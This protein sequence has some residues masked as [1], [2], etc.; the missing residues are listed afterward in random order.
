M[1]HQNELTDEELA[2]ASGGANAL[3]DAFVQGFNNGRARKQRLHP[4]LPELDRGVLLG[5]WR[6][7]RFNAC[8]S[9]RAPIATV[10]SIDLRQGSFVRLDRFSR[11]GPRIE[12][13]LDAD[14]GIRL[15]DHGWANAGDA[16]GLVSGKS[17][18]ACGS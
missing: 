16:I 13:G 8:C 10:L 17:H 3:I 9:A 7:A 11:H 2:I 18:L 14:R 12:V 1:Q 6:L 5:I 15:A 4:C